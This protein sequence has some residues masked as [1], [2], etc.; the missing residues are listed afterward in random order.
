MDYVHS[1]QVRVHTPTLV[2]Y[3]FR[4]QLFAFKFT[5]NFAFEALQSQGLIII[6]C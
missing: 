3:T 6:K 2:S 1:V 4:Y 5:A